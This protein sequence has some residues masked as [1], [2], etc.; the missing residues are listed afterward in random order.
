M[1]DKITQEQLEQDKI[2]YLKGTTQEDQDTHE[3]L[4]YLLDKH[5]LDEIKLRKEIQ[6][7]EYEESLKEFQEQQKIKYLR[8]DEVKTKIVDVINKTE[9]NTILVIET[10]PGSGK[11]Y[12][13][14]KTLINK[15]K[16]E[17]KILLVLFPRHENAKEWLENDFKEEKIFH[18]KGFDYIHKNG[19]CEFSS[20]EKHIIDECN[21]YEISYSKIISEQHR[22]RLKLEGKKCPYYEQKELVK[23]YKII[24]GAHQHLSTKFVD[25]INPDF[26]IID[27]NAIKNL[28]IK[29]EFS[30]DVAKGKNNKPLG[31]S[32]NKILDG[33]NRYTKKRLESCKDNKERNGLRYGLRKMFRPYVA[34]VESFI[35]LIN[36]IK[37]KEDGTYFFSYSDK[38]LDWKNFLLRVHEK[39]LM[40]SQGIIKYGALSFIDGLDKFTHAE[41]I[42]EQAIETD[43]GGVLYGLEKNNDLEHLFKPITGKDI[44]NVIAPER[45]ITY[46]QNIRIIKSGNRVWLEYWYIDYESLEKLKDRTVVICDATGNVFYKKIAERLGMKLTKFKPNIEPYNRDIT[47]FSDAYYTK[48]GLLTKST[49]KNGYK[50]PWR[51]LY[52]IAK[53]IVEDRN[54][55]DDKVWFIARIDVEN[56]LKKVIEQDKRNFNTEHYNNLTGLNKIKDSQLIFLFG[57]AEPRTD[58]VWKE[59][60]LLCDK[61]IPYEKRD[62]K[63]N[64][65]FKSSELNTVLKMEREDEMFQALER[66]RFF[67]TTKYKKG[68]F[69]FS[70][71]PL[72]GNE[73]TEQEIHENYVD[74][75]FLIYGKYNQLMTWVT[76][77]KMFLMKMGVIK[78]LKEKGELTTAKLNKSLMAWLKKY[79][80]GYST[81][82]YPLFKW[83][84]KTRLDFGRIGF[85]LEKGKTKPTK[86]W[87]LKDNFHFPII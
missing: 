66:I 46:N 59:T 9:K 35:S 22:E 45:M 25:E 51:K 44:K 78:I 7:Q 85:K 75:N 47:Q 18:L 67:T 23:D 6:E 56:E 87:F 11:T 55:Q 80:Y 2:N 31:G 63:R 4:E 57:V 81:Q 60:M 61:Y 41:S 76:T 49:S 24:F 39:Y 48:T 65:Y 52:E 13:S 26:V 84:L 37:E 54:V 58:I 28:V 64:P 62:Y 53:L 42:I 79:G 70:K 10:C 74:T 33:I 43:I 14:I 12:N 30:I 5:E 69:I 21:K 36:D 27:E 77:E 86:I 16:T 71:I 8:R 15:A 32:L 83:V 20:E 29:K 19:E 72:C 82:N 50:Y 38:S 1:S 40:S 68:A 17:N 73:V 3:Q 34:V